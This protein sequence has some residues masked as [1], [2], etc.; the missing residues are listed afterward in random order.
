MTI[1]SFEFL[2]KIT[3]NSKFSLR[4]SYAVHYFLDFSRCINF[5]FLLIL[6]KDKL[7]LINLIH[8]MKFIHFFC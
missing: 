3:L 2:L 6:L 1:L 8:F 5:E 7:S 4:N